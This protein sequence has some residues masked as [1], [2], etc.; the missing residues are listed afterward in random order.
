MKNNITQLAQDLVERL[1]GEKSKLIHIEVLENSSLDQF[2]IDSS[3]GKGPIIR[4]NNVVSIASGLNHYL[5]YFCKCHISW[6]G[7]QLD[8]PSP[9]PEP[10]QVIIKNA[11]CDWRYYLNFCTF[12]YSMPWWDWQRWEKEIDWMALHGINMP[13]A[14]TGHEYT[15]IKI[16]EQFGIDSS[17]IKEFLAGP[18]YFAWHHMGNIDGI[19]GPLTD[20]FIN[21]QKDLQERILQRERAFGMTPVLHGFYG[22]V[23]KEFVELFPKA[24]ITQLDNWFDAVGTYFLDPVD[25]LFQEV[26][27][28]FY[29]EQEALYGTNHLYAMD[30]F[31]EGSSPK[32]DDNYK[33]TRGKAVMDNL[34]SHDPRGTWVMQ[35][36]SMQD[37]ILSMLPKEHL[38]LLDLRGEHKPKWDKKDAFKEVNWIWCLLHNFGGRHGLSGNPFKVHENFL[39]AYKGTCH[40]TLKGIGLTPEAIEETPIFYDLVS[41]LVWEN[42]ENIDMG[43][44]IK[45]FLER[46]Y[47]SLPETVLDAWYILLDSV[48]KGVNNFGPTDSILCA[49][50]APAIKKVVVSQVQ[51][52]YDIRKLLDALKL[53]IKVPAKLISKDTYIYDLI[54]LMR[55][56]LAMYARPIYISMMESY[57]KKDLEGLNKHWNLL[58]ELF[59]DLDDLLGRHDSFMLGPWLESAK[60]LGHNEA[61]KEL[62]AY[63]AQMQVTRWWPEV[64][65]HDYAHKHWSGLMKDFYLPR[66]QIFHKGLEGALMSNTTPDFAALEEE[67]VAWEYSWIEKT[68]SYTTIPDSNVYQRIVDLSLKYENIFPLYNDK[69]GMTYEETLDL[70]TI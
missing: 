26:A 30:L 1:L 37:S 22:H 47:S 57:Y 24:E 4:G 7:N 46:R 67:I 41:D 40:H 31:H 70:H 13:L 35:S 36:W 25:P 61:E 38:L 29:K 8:L 56:I 66:W 28:V 53:M 60:A 5:K 64:S 9:L 27:Q 58:E 2:Q 42:P 17:K 68:H 14:I 43:Q 23:P 12:S 52:Y 18:A 19:G 15:W 34:L 39:A 49:R 11:V 51:P 54:D 16:G 3:G 48:Y 20:E 33:A 55:E 50:P 10:T 63:N 65:F 59:I 62:L 45:N 44:W 21:Y 32:D 6:C 69:V